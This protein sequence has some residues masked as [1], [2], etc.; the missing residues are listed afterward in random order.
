MSSIDEVVTTNI[1]LTTVDSSVTISG[2]SSATTQVDSISFLTGPKGDQGDPATNLV[3]SVN[4]KQ[5]VVVLNA[6]DVG[7]DHT[8]SASQALQDAKD[9]TDTEVSTLDSS[10]ATVAKTGSYDDLSNKP[11][12]PS[13]AGLA[14]E[15]QVQDVQDN[16]DAH[17]ADTANPHNVTKAHVGLGNVDNTSDANK[18]VSTAQQTALNGKQNSDPTLTALA[19]Y[20]T[21]GILTQTSAD[22]FTGRT[23]TG[24]A[25]QITVTNGNGVSGNPTLSL[26]QDIHT[27]AGPVFDRLN[28]G[29]GTGA[30]SGDYRIYNPANSAHYT[31]FWVDQ[32][33]TRINSVGNSGFVFQGGT[34]LLE[35]TNL[36]FKQHARPEANL[37]YDLGTTSYWYRNTYTN[38]L[39]L[40]STATLDGSTAGEIK[41]TGIFTADNI[42]RGTGFP[43]GVVTANV[44]TVYID[45][46]IT[47]G[48]SS[49]IKKSG[50]GSTGWKVLEGDTGWRNLG[51]LWP[52]ITENIIL[53]RIG[54]VCYVTSQGD[55][56][57]I[58]S[59]V[60]NN[61][62]LMELGFK[63]S[64][65]TELLITNNGSVVGRILAKQ[66][67]QS[68]FLTTNTTGTYN[69]IANSS[70]LTTNAWPTT[71][72]G[73]AA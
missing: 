64:G 55:G 29:G 58:V 45:T 51:Q 68:L 1:D 6:T 22:T 69:A 65:R 42:K 59:T 7:A 11:T 20:N 27:G 3:Q 28:V 57:T 30:V 13:I 63:P 16:L 15:A 8:G 40:N 52:Q 66:F 67:D 25:N 50:T 33:W 53:R 19:A 39:F 18:P 43:E 17:E 54:D 12:I 36:V 32:Y 41:G 14:T 10:L 2:V 60:I 56:L 48:A 35:P 31:R 37:T 70:Y 47:N 5:G 61:S 9:Y 62:R 71:L 23:I 38:K 73:T 44:G 26:P 34:V 46:A 49:W 4:G 24:T 72:P 21:N